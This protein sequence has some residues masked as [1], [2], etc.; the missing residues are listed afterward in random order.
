MVEQKAAYWRARL[1]LATIFMVVGCGIVVQLLIAGYS[2]HLQ[3]DSIYQFSLTIGLFMSAMG[4]GSYITQRVEG[5]LVA[6]LAWVYWSFA[7]SASATIFFLGLVDQWTA[8]FALLSHLWTFWIGGHIGFLLPLAIRIVERDLPLPRLLAQVMFFDYLGALA[9][10]LFF[11]WVLLPRLGFADGALC[12]GLLVLVALGLLCAAFWQEMRMRRVLQ[13]MAVGWV[14]VIALA[15]GRVEPL[16]EA[17]AARSMPH[18]VKVHSERSRYQ[19]I[20]FVRTERDYFLSLNRFPQFSSQDEYRYHES[21]VHLAMHRARQHKRILILGGGDGLALRDLWRYAEVEEVV[22]V[23]L[24]P[25]MTRFGQQHPIMRKL[26][27]DAMMPPKERSF[28]LY[29][30]HCTGER[31][32]SCERGQRQ[33]LFQ[34]RLASKKT[35][36]PPLPAHKRPKALGWRIQERRIQHTPRLEIRNEDAWKYIGQ[37]GKAFDVILSDLPDATNIS[38]SKL[39]SIEFYRLLRRRLAKGGAMAVQSTTVAPGYRKAF[40]C[41]ANTIEAA[42]FFT[43]AYHAWLPSF[44]LHTSFVLATDTPEKLTQLSLTIPT[45]FLHDRLLPAMLWFPKD[46]AQ[47][48]TRINRIDTHILLRYLLKTSL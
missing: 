7:V 16:L 31:G 26:N 35:A 27:E 39:Y 8:N 4:V 21:L 24:D 11:P 32:A 2:S 12:A 40:W 33:R 5:E 30:A 19:E 25:A 3:G 14:I 38:L 37:T 22:M 9:G 15:W 43:Q 46:I 42:G 47:V 1:L 18:A 28:C 17:L 34:Y 36:C 13:R 44:G 10:S 23:D 48:K 41:I 6:R 20:R 45:R 29:E